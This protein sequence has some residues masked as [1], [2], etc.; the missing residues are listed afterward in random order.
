MTMFSLFQ[1]NDG[2][3]YCQIYVSTDNMSLVDHAK[4]NAN[5]AKITAR[6]GNSGVIVSFDVQHA[7]KLA[8]A[9]L[10]SV[11]SSLKTFND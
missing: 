8:D 6:L 9:R 11:V 3:K 2:W 4:L 10:F 7:V 5:M 1:I